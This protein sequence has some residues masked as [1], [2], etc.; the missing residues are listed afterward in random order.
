MTNF[1]YDKLLAS[2]MENIFN[3]VVCHKNKKTK[4]S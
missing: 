2:L 4:K 1:L 3:N